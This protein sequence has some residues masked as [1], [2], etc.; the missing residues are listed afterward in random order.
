MH[1]GVHRLHEPLL[2]EGIRLCSAMMLA[3]SF[4]VID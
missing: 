3:I 1:R 4:K 2:P